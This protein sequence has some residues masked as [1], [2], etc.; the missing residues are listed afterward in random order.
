MSKFRTAYSKRERFEAPVGTHEVPTFGF[1]NDGELVVNGKTNLFAEI[2]SHECET[3]L[4]NII[5]RCRLTGET[6][7]AP[8]S[9]F[10]DSTTMPQSLVDLQDQVNKVESFTA[11]LSADDL[12]L[13]RSKGFDEYI[14]VKIAAA[15]AAKSEVKQDEQ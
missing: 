15:T 14:N 5:E 6:L 11:S 12:E 1:D 3:L 7:L 13:I 8:D 2:Q 10:G 4:S 9:A